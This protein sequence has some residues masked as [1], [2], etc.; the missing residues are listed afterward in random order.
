MAD[1]GIDS[2]RDFKKMSE[3]EMREAKRKKAAPHKA[4]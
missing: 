2:R 3:V 1:P 4:V